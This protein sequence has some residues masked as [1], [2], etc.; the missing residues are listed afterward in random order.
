MKHLSNCIKNVMSKSC[1]NR[2]FQ[3]IREFARDKALTR[4][5]N[6]SLEKMRRMFWK[7]TCGAAFSKWRQTEYEQALEM[8]SMTEETCQQLTEDH[9]DKKRVI[10][11]QNITRSA[12]IVGK[13]Q[14]H[15]FYQ[16]WKNVTRWLKHKR[17]ATANLLEAQSSY[18]VKRL[19]KKWRARKD[20]TVAARAAYTKFQIKRDLLYTRAV[21]RELMLKHHR[22]KALAVRLS[23]TAGKFDS[24]MLESAFQLIKNFSTAKQNVHAHQKELS[25]RDIGGVLQKIYRRKLLQH[26]SHLRRQVH[27]DKV[28]AH[29]KKV[30]FGHFISMQVRDAFN[31]WKKQAVFAQTVIEVNE[32]GPVV[33]EVLQSRLDVTNLKNLMT[34][35]GFTSHQIDDVAHK[36]DQKSLELIARSIGRWKTWNGTDDYLK[37]KVFDRWRRFVHYRK[38]VKHWLDFM[39]NRQQHGKADLSF[40]FLKWK[41]FFADK[42]NLLQR[43][44]YAQL[45]TRAVLAAKR[46]DTLAD[47]T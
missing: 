20:T 3:N 1:W 29:K 18:A 33:E 44:T 43:R 8:I 37:P 47:S 31:R 42:Q 9:L 35:E 38:I 15:K 11:K 14:K 2:G 32:I 36:A 28:V 30:M 26:Y 17:V 10:Q 19:I 5:Q 13:S 22:D 7:R 4:N 46:L 25:S 40:C 24:R 41:H 39:S 12:K 45:K 16:A 23:N 27:G 6:S 21:F 34:Q